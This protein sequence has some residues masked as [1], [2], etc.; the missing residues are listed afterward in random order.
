[1]RA[2]LCTSGGLPGA[3]VLEVLAADPRIEIA[4]IVRSTRVLHARYSFLRGAWRQWR[5]SGLHYT[6][7]LGLALMKRLPAQAHATREVNS[8][9]AREF[10]AACRPDL[11]VSAFFN[12]RIGA[13]ICALAPALNIHPSLL[14]A[15]RGVD[16]VFYARLAGAPLGV[17]VHRVA[18]ELDAGELIAQQAVAIADDESVLAAT[19]RL[20]ECGAQLLLSNLQTLPQPQRGPANYD[21]W[22]SPA[23]VAA[24]RGKGIRLARLRD[25]RFRAAEARAPR[26]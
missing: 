22:P 11:I 23:Q 14:P 16:P 25:L 12:Q 21:S 2:V 10:I 24:L 20:Y 6:V 1:M 9:A 15:F 13:Q 8:Q 17:S 19:C 26:R 7:Y 4:G 18:P 3:A 5:R